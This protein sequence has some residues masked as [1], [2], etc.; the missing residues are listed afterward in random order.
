MD[1]NALAILALLVMLLGAVGMFVPGVPGMPL[2]WLAALAYALLDGF[3]H[4]GILQF[5]LIT[6]LALVG[7]AAGILTTQAGVRAGGGSRASG[8]I[9]S[10][11]VVLGLI[12]FT[13][14]VAIAAA[15]L[16]VFGSEWRRKRSPTSAAKSSAGWLGGYLFSTLVELFF[17]VLIIMIFL[18]SVAT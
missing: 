9:G 15:L 18:W 3:H 2:V 12:F 16:G 1:S 8:I 10:C 5:I 11:I 14:P 13:V 17:A 6:L 4:L 7:A